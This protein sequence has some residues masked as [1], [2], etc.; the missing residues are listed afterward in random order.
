MRVFFDEDF[1]KIIPKHAFYIRLRLPK[2]IETAYA[3]EI[4]YLP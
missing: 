3:L 1:Q 4:A 2:M